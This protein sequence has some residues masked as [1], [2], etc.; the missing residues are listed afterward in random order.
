MILE[1]LDLQQQSDDCYF[2]DVEFDYGQ[3]I[4]GGQLVAQ[5]L[6]AAY[7]SVDEPFIC[8]SMHLYFLR[9]GW[10]KN[11]T[12]FRVRRLRD[13]RSFAHREVDIEQEGKLI[14]RVMLSFQVAEQ[15]LEHQQKAAKPLPDPL[16][17]PLERDLV[18]GA[19]LALTDEVQRWFDLPIETRVVAPIDFANPKPMEPSNPMWFR[20]S[21]NVSGLSLPIRQCLLAYLTDY[22]LLDAG[23][24]AQGVNWWKDQHVLSTSLD[25]SLWFHQ[26]ADVGDW[27]YF[28]HFSPIAR[29]GRC[30]N[31]GEVFSPSGQLL[32]SIAQ[33]GLLRTAER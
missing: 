32:A 12:L 10:P 30:F 28:D 23:L 17:Y 19:G 5:A 8:H 7:F 11:R 26:P 18:M 16:Q 9:P 6:R 27:L 29:G 33:E 24:R 31:R 15:G 3:S 21:L 4:Y 1:L 2:S 14:A 22:G 25:H 13:G 20:Y